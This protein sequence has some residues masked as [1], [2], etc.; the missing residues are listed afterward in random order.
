MSSTRLHRDRPTWMAYLATAGYIW[1][2][3]GMG[4]AL[5]LL[6]DET[7]MSRTVASL[8]SSVMAIG[9]LLVGA[10]GAALTRT[11]GRRRTL[12]LGMLG[13]T[14]GVLLLAF[15]GTPALS[16]PGAMLMGFSGS[17]VLNTQSAFLA[18][19]HGDLG[20]SAMGEQNAAGGIAGLLAP[21]S[22]GL[23]ATSAV[24]WRLALLVGPA[25]FVLVLLLRGRSADTTTA[26]ELAHQHGGRLPRTY[27]W[28]WAGLALCI[29]VEFSFIM[30][31]G[32]VLRAQTGASVA[33]AAGGLTAVAAG[34]VIAR[35][36][37][38]ALLRRIGLE[39]LFRLSLL[40]PALAWIP[41][42]LSTSAAV[43]LVCM[44]V[45]GLGIGLHY[46]LGLARMVLRAPGHADLAA[47]RSAFASGIAIGLA[48]L[49][50]GALADGV[51]V[52]TAFIT[53]PALLLAAVA[54]MRTDASTTA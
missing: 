34:I 43:V 3:Y 11:L 48:P 31:A 41:M 16:I 44:A 14:I 6:R 45:I 37:I 46:P 40:V 53:I 18:V 36:S 39:Q 33:L 1:G 7:D 8:H 29:A 26:P 38:P 4:P 2:L 5:L 23:I 13:S 9:F 42:W 54:T 15:G 21:L 52:H 19:H 50:L 47:N 28:A 25:A 51:G 35:T 12:D 10:V 24:N 17:I 32:D 20:P 49:G 22:L 30:W 27:W